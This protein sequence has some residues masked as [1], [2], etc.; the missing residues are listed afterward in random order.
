MT[1]AGS[2]ERTDLRERTRTQTLP[3]LGWVKRGAGGSPGAAHWP[4]P[5]LVVSQAYKKAEGGGI[6]SSGHGSLFPE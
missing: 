2:P 5:S 3:R 6:Y 1:G 4:F